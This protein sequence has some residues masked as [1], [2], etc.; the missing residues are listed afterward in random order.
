VAR[1][2]LKAGMAA[3]C[4]LSQDPFRGRVIAGKY[5]LDGLLGEGGMGAVWRAFNLPEP[6]LLEPY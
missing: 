6:A 4:S 1:K 5:R 3:V 2:L